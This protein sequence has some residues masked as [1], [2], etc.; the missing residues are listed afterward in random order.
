MDESEPEQLHEEPGDWGLNYFN[1][2][3]EVEEHFRQARGTSLF[4]LSPVDW[5]LID[6]W[7][8]GGVSLEAVL[9]GIDDAFAAWRSRKNRRRQVNSVAYCAQA[10]MERAKRS[11]S[12]SRQITSAAEAPFSC[13]ELAAHLHH[14][15]GRL[16][17]RA[18]TA[19]LEIATALENIAAQPEQHLADL[20]S[21]EQRLSAMEDKAVAALRASQ[22]EEDLFAIRQALDAE[23]RP[24]RGKMSAEQL[25]M[26]ERRY[27]DNALLERANL[28][29]LSLFYI[30]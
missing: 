14:A 26:L 7:R 6:N 13:V 30:R 18:E 2:F 8:T 21:L 15:S 16:R 29:R 28:P 3:T 22:S 5:A 27:L 17:A 19:L 20:E 9:R 25:A 12:R 4:L 11:S 1:Y 10:V 24:Y 23:L